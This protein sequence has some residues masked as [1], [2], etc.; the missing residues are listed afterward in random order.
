MSIEYRLTL[1]AD[2]DHE[3]VVAI[4]HAIRRDDHIS[5]EGLDDWELTQRNA[6]RLSG[7]WLASL[8]SS[9]VGT[10]SFGH[11]PWFDS[12]LMF[13]HVMVHPDCQGLGY[14]S[15][16]L[17]RAEASAH[18]H[19]VRRL[20]GHAEESDTRTLGFLARSGYDEIDR[21][22]RSILDLDAFDPSSWREMIE[23]VR[24]GGIRFATVASLRARRA[25]WQVELRRLYGDLEAD[26]PT[27]LDLLEMPI[28]DFEA[29]V[30]G[31]QL[32]ADGFFVALDGDTMVGLTEPQLVDG[33]P[34]ALSQSLTGV[35]SGYRGRGI[36]VA[37]K[38]VSATWAKAQ[39]YRSIRTHNAQSNVPMLAVND[40]LGFERDVAQVEVLK[41]L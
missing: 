25:D 36:A 17:Q 37:L 40:R 8:D 16:L 41:T 34:S 9:I 23:I 29:I 21:G 30:L 35:R 2:Y 19:G 39:G 12:D 4:A 10:A 3:A 14:G 24:V 5:V 31:R 18:G 26:V 20:L 13:V 11:S 38:A 33:D 1:D 27:R 22:W 7:R 15:G 32:L 6:G 28:E